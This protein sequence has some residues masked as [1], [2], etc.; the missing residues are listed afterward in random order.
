MAF[1]GSV[2][3]V[4]ATDSGAQAQDTPTEDA[5]TE[6]GPTEDAPTDEAPPE[7]TPTEDVP[8]Q[9]TPTEDA[10]TGETPPEDTPTEDASTGETPPEDTPTEETSTDDTPAPDES[11]SVTSGHYGCPER[12]PSRYHADVPSWDDWCLDAEY[13][14]VEVTCSSTH[15]NAGQTVRFD[16]EPPVIP[17]LVM[18]DLCGYADLISECPPTEPAAGLSDTSAR[19]GDEI[20]DPAVELDETSGAAFELGDTAEAALGPD[21]ISEL[22]LDLDEITDVASDLDEIPDVASDLDE[23]PDLALGPD[24]TTDAPADL[25]EMTDAVVAPDEPCGPPW[26]PG[27]WYQYSRQDPI[28]GAVTAGGR[29][30]GAWLGVRHHAAVETPSL[31]VHC[32]AG[33]LSVVVHTGGVVV[34]TYGRGIPVDYRIGET[35]RFEEWN[36][37]E[38]GHSRRAGVS[39]PPWFTSTFMELLGDNSEGDF[40]IRVFGHDGA[41]VGTAQFDLAAIEK[42]VVP[43]LEICVT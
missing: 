4:A 9:D 27:T 24:E 23:I 16:T 5:P 6:D 20:T 19:G 33:K 15:A 39:L 28:T 2:L 22:T 13:W 30:A 1:L 18:Y 32:A 17:Q 12:P 21:E 29:A 40:L 34:A 25:G 7:D 3:F 43:I 8:P 38:T 36:E 10:S 11:H 26:P 42:M 37:V 31:L 14:I 35:I 41:E